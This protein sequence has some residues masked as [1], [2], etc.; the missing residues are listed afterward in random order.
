MMLERGT[1]YVRI[2]IVDDDLSG[3]RLMQFLLTEQG[4]SVDTV[5][6]AHGALALIARQPPDL[7]LLDVN[8]PQLNGFEIYQR[9]REEDW[10]IPVIFVTAKGELEDRLQ[11]MRMGAYD[12]ICNPFQPA[13]HH[14]RVEV[15]LVLYRKAR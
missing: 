14:A 1:N 3:S 13:V 5:D 4:Y 15:A 9:L 11:G 8:L 12:Y 6:N 7:I 10:D 2:L